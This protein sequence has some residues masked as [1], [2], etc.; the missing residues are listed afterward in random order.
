MMTSRS[1]VILGIDPGARAGLAVIEPDRVWTRTARARDIIAARNELAS[2]G[3]TP[4]AVGIEGQYVG[5]NARSSLSVARNAE[6]WRCA[7]ELLGWR[8]LPLVE[9]NKWRSRG[10]SA[11]VSKP[12][13]QAKAA[14]LA[15]ARRVY[16]VDVSVD[17][18]EAL[19]IAHWAWEEVER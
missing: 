18:A 14:V 13:E 3:V 15:W 5:R 2:L 1:E 8:V 16:G 7:A 12:R 9:P 10:P 11:A 4:R 6:M 19:G 17:E